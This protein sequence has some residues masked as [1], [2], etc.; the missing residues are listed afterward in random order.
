MVLTACLLLQ[1]SAVC[2][3]EAQCHP[4]MAGEAPRLCEETGG[5]VVPQCMQQ[6]AAQTCSRACTLLGC[7]MCSHPPWFLQEEYSDITTLEQRLQQV[8]RTFVSSKNNRQ[9]QAQQQQ[10]PAS[11]GP[12]GSQGGSAP[13]ASTAAPSVLLQQQQGQ[14]LFPGQV[15]GG[16]Q[17]NAMMNGLGGPGSLMPGAGMPYQM[18]SAALVANGMSGL[19]SRAMPGVGP[20][21]QPLMS[22]PA[23]GQ[24]GID[25]GMGLIGMSPL[26]QQAAALRSQ[27]ASPASVMGN[28]K[29][30]PAGVLR[31]SAARDQAT[32]PQSSLGGST[33]SCLHCAGRSAAIL[34]STGCMGHH[35]CNVRA[36]LGLHKLRSTHLGWS[37][38]L[39]L[40]LA[41]H[42]THAIHHTSYA[43]L[44]ASF[45][46]MQAVPH[47]AR[48]LVNGELVP[49]LLCQ[50]LRAC[51]TAACDWPAQC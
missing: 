19:G 49:A 40:C 7:T 24:P 45:I 9:Q 47:Q 48:G 43:W 27:A 41:S 37:D 6:G 35:M 18:A 31:G 3:K 32:G 51:Y 20:Q 15:P 22:S 23:L 8:A 21:A 39:H 50:R 34:G 44:I 14:Q 25:P 28:G 42:E 4:G 2:S 30:L 10:R 46:G 38:V 13:S 5:G 33:V 1:L 12:P 11:E 29:P 17:R 16:L 26:Q 36:T